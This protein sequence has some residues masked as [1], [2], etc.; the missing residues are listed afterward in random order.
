MINVCW[1][2]WL[3]LT[4]TKRLICQVF[5]KVGNILMQKMYGW[6]YLLLGL[7]RTYSSA[8]VELLAVEMK[9]K[10]RKTR[11]GM[12]NMWVSCLWITCSL[13]D[14]CCC[15]FLRNRYQPITFCGATQTIGQ[16]PVRQ[17]N[18]KQNK[19]FELLHQTHFAYIKAHLLLGILPRCSKGFH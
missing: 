11:S 8:C 9:L 16:G 4:S 7:K 17:A 6:L 13:N 14:I 12:P 19:T 3:I 1:A 10:R 5:F 18:I 2:I 15:V